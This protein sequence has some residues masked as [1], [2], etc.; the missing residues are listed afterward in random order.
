MQELRKSQNRDLRADPAWSINSEKMESSPGD[1]PGFRRLRV[2]GICPLPL[3]DNS[4]KEF[5]DFHCS[6]FRIK[7]KFSCAQVFLHPLHVSVMVWVTSTNEDVICDCEHTG[8]IKQHIIQVLLKSIA[9]DFQTRG[10][11]ITPISTKRNYLAVNLS[12]FWMRHPA[13]RAEMQKSSSSLARWIILMNNWTFFL[14]INRTDVILINIHRITRL[15]FRQQVTRYTCS[16]RTEMFSKL[17]PL[18]S[19]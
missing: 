3:F 12:I 15:L 16:T 7:L 14:H 1:F 4:R 13:S 9:A 17:V 8:L 11:F 18:T 5:H 6:F 19:S 10:N 2:S